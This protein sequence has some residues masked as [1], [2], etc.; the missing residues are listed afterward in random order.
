V[1]FILSGALGFIALAL[2]F[3]FGEPVRR[4]VAL[5]LKR[6]L[7]V[8]TMYRYLTRNWGVFA[9]FY[10]G[11]AIWSAASYGTGAWYATFL[12][13]RFHLHPQEVGAWF[14]GLTALVGLA[15]PTLAGF[16]VDRAAKAGLRTGN[17]ILLIFLPLPPLLAVLAPFA[18]NPV[19][20][21][22][23]SL[24]LTGT[25]PM[26]GVVTLAVGQ[27]IMPSNMRGLS[28]SLFVI[29]NTIIGATG[30][31]LLIAMATEHLFKDTQK[32][33]YSIAMLDLPACLLASAVFFIGWINL[34]R[35]LRRPGDMAALMGE[36]R[37][38]AL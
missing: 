33:G 26:I 7:D 22:L 5:Q 9:P 38:P 4:G 37:A 24:A 2:L 16:L 23:L 28:V 14:G 30:G 12:F 15:G 25:A 32:I 31:P 17:F 29:F 27:Q 1:V 35:A 19:A 8:G 6:G 34:K 36:D 10:L 21:V 20:S 11:F 3:T 18:P 13:R